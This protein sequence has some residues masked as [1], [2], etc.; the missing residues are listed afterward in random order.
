MKKIY[1]YLLAVIIV[2][3]C[4]VSVLDRAGFHVQS[5]IGNAV[6]AAVLFLPI[7]MLL[8]ILG[9]DGDL[10]KG[11]RACCKVAFW[12]VLIS[13]LAGGIALLAEQWMC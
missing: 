7:E 9:R 12:F 2:E 6:G 8:F 3:I 10:S 5:W 1:K 4:I 11:W 13:Y